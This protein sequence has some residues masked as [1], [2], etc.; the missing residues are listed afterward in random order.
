MERNI[1]IVT[2]IKYIDPNK[3]HH[4]SA[5]NYLLSLKID[6]YHCECTLKHDILKE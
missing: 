3:T 2:C 5:W 1:Y 4:M 6:G